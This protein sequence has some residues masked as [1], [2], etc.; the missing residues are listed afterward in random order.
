[1]NSSGMFPYTCIKFKLSLV[2]AVNLGLFHLH[3][4]FI[5]LG[6]QCTLHAHVFAWKF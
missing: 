5:S 2:S 3:P 1:M 4:I 6:L